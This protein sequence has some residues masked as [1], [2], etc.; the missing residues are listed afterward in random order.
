MSETGVAEQRPKRTRR[1]IIWWSVAGVVVL[2]VACAVWVT[3]RALNA[4]SELE[5]SLPL[6]QTVQSQI[7]S[8]D[9]KAAKATAQNLAAHLD[10]ARDDTNDPIWRAA[11]II[12]GIGANLSAVRQLASA[13]SDVTDHAIVPVA[14]LAGTVDFSSFRPVDGKVPLQPLTDA[15]PTMTRADSAVQSGLKT[16][17]SIDTSAT[18]GPVTK[19]TGTLKDALE[20]AGGEVDAAARATRLLPA[21]LGAD[22]PR[23]YLLIMQNNAEARSTGGI[24]G[25]VAQLHVDDGSITLVRQAS[26]GDFPA[27]SEPVLPLT[28]ATKALYGDIT[29]EYLQDVTL[30]PDFPVSAELVRAMWQKRFGTQVDGVFSID[31]VALGDVLAATG[32]VDVGD[33]TQLTSDNA[34]Q[35]LLSE[36]YARYADPQEQDAFFAAATSAVFTKVANGQFDPTAM[37]TGLST[38]AGERRILLWSANAKEQSLLA[39]TTLAGGLPSGTDADRLFGVYLNDATGAKMDYYL[40]T[41]VQ[42][43]QAQCRSDGRADYVVRVTLAS[44]APADAGTA[45]PWYVTGGGLSGVAPGDIHTTVAVYAP[46]GSIVVGASTGGADVPVQRITDDGH[47]VAH[48]Q[49]ALS[50]GQRSTYEFHF[51]GA[52]ADKKSGVSAGVRPTAVV[53]P[54][55]WPSTVGPAELSCSQIGH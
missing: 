38:A 30:T 50:P 1:R 19:A 4:K 39:Q 36:A 17:R 20:K 55:V 54:G 47:S 25:A 18:I 52:P 41:K 44:S 13:A 27:P 23:D 37:L 10:T 3:V 9:A 33:G 35:V 49:I 31:P 26:A 7:A 8:G 51:V 34:V 14:G 11:E 29:G 28:A 43:A 6:V 5:A 32:P 22:G 24:V 15:A 53:T 21:M 2:L 16:V 45:L 46:K 40:H 48:L 42:V 12:P